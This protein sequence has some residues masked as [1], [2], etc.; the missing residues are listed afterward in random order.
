[1]GEAKEREDGDRG[2]G[3][4]Q[5]QQQRFKGKR[6]AD[7]AGLASRSED[8]KE[9]G[10]TGGSKYCS[11]RLYITGAEEG[12]VGPRLVSC[13]PAGCLSIHFKQVI[14]ITSCKAIVHIILDPL[15]PTE[16]HELCPGD[17]HTT[18]PRAPEQLSYSARAQRPASIV[19]IVIHMRQGHIMVALRPSG[20][21]WG[22]NRVFEKR[23]LFEGPVWLVRVQQQ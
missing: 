5:Q 23:K 10:E 7:D 16:L 22:A 19:T 3:K 12:P 20:T 13:A 21:F 17:R 9:L 8:E 2:E 6:S 14:S 4:S 18:K 1:M 11:L 15:S